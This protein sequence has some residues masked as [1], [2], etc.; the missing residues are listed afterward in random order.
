MG[1]RIPSTISHVRNLISFN[2]ARNQFSG[3]IPPIY[4]I[5]SLEY[6]FIHTHRF[7][8]SLPLDIGVNL[9][10]LRYFSIS[11]NN[12]T[13]SLQDSLSTATNLQGLEI[14]GNIFSGKVSINFSRL[15]NLSRLNLGENNLGTGTANDL[16]FI[17]LLTNY[18]KL[19]VLDLHS[20]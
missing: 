6:I 4:N 1:G 5:S 19:E 20:N 13:G 17:T 10:N 3:I 9:A 16:D 8:G 7:H 2:V 14:N 15:Q 18:T 11:G 12:L